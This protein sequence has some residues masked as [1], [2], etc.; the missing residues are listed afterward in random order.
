MRFFRFFSLVTCLSLILSFP[1]QAGSLADTLKRSISA[2][3]S[4]LT[5]FK[6]QWE[7]APAGPDKVK[8][9][10]KIKNLEAQ[11][12]ALKN[13]LV[14]PSKATAAPGTIKQPTTQTPSG[15][16]PATKT[17]DQ[18][19]GKDWRKMS[20]ADRERF[21]YMGVGSLERR[22]VFIAKPPGDYVQTLN[23]VL[24]TNPEL[25]DEFLEDLFVFCVYDSEPQTRPAIS[26][27]RTETEN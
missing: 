5:K 27:L 16:E 21:I 11:N 25:S 1:V 15:P 7:A 3:K 23:T 8:L 20:A 26:R 6:K 14:K 9:E 10:N 18:L 22:G 13:Q 24:E 19:Q 12:N 4:M 17:L 2:N